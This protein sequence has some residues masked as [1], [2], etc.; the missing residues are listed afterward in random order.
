[1]MRRRLTIAM[2]SWTLVFPGVARAQAPPVAA[3]T[4]LSDAPPPD[5]LRDPA[6]ETTT[7]SVPGA[8][9]A[10]SK[11]TIATDASYG[12]AVGNPVKVG[13]GGMYA[14]A[15]EIRYFNALRGPAGQGI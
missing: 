15:R 5:Q 6:H 10:S 14:G 2:F 4:Q 3:T 13:G 1:M 11:C 9:A 12:Y 7:P 8:N